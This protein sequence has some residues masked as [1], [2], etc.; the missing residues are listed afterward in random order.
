MGE[1]SIALEH[2]KV[3]REQRANGAAKGVWTGAWKG[4]TATLK[5]KFSPEDANFFPAVC[6]FFYFPC[7]TLEFYMS[8]N[9][10]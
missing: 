10:L 9:S 4:R 8:S 3:S 5:P 6:K 7:A 1:K 2:P